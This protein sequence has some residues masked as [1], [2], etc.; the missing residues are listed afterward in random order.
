MPDWAGSIAMF[1]VEAHDY[2]PKLLAEITRLRSRLAEVAE[3][4]SPM[5]GDCGYCAD[6]TGGAHSWPCPTA[7]LA[8]ADVA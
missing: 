5:G 7:K 1:L 2:V 3:L 8:A 4:H 6:E